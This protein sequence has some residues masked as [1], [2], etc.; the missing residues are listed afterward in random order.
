MSHDETREEAVGE[1]TTVELT[2]A[3]TERALEAR[4][5]ALEAEN[6]HWRQRLAESTA[7]NTRLSLQLTAAEVKTTAIAA[8][9][10]KTEAGL[11]EQLIAANVQRSVSSSMTLRKAT[12]EHELRK[13]KYEQSEKEYLACMAT[14][15]GPSPQDRPK[16]LAVAAAVGMVIVATVM[17]VLLSDSTIGY[18]VLSNRYA[19]LLPVT[20][21]TPIVHYFN[22]SGMN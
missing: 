12:R 13:E 6:S 10:M 9:N 7:E 18:G 3:K 11:R 2:T 8:S 17:A 4:V 16:Y 22:N 21:A 20:A 1:L 14:G 5:A 19:L 15:Q